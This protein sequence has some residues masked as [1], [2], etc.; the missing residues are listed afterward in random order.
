MESGLEGENRDLRAKNSQLRT[1]FNN[2]RSL[3]KT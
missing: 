1:R 2:T 3:K